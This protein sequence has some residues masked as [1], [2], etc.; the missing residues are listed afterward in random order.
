MLGHELRQTN[1]MNVLGSVTVSDGLSQK[2]H[3]LD[4]QPGATSMASMYR[5]ARF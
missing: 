3:L 1:Q 5:H 4:Y 2:L